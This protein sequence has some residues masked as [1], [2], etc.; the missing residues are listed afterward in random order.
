MTKVFLGLGSNLG[1][2]KA[3]LE[4]A[5]SCLKEKTKIV[6]CSSLYK[7]EPVGY[8]NQNDFYN[9]VI[10]IE[11]RLQPKK[12]LTFLQKIEKK[13]GKKKKRKN[14][15]RTIDID[16]LLYDRLVIKEKNLIIPHPRMHERRFVLIPLKEI[17]PKFVHPKM[18]KSI[19]E[20]LRSV[21]EKK[22]VRKL[23]R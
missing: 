8:G 18:K 14:G 19:S 4:K 7:T 15:P 6:A 17:A 1:D 21:K 20:L 22:R 5:M 3:Y 11:T 23:T 9:R 13:L 10:E 2:R 16:I 12:L